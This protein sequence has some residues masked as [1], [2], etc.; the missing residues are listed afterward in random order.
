MSSG[1]SCVPRLECAEDVGQW[2]ASHTSGMQ[3]RVWRVSAC[4]WAANVRP[5]RA[6]T[7]VARMSVGDAMPRDRACLAMLVVVLLVAGCTPGR[8]APQAA[9]STAAETSTSDRL[10]PRTALPASATTVVAGSRAADLAIGTSRALFVSSPVVVLAGEDDEASITKAATTAADL[11]VPMLLTPAPAAPGAVDTAAAASGA[12]ADLRA[13]LSR[14]AVQS[15][16]TIGDRA[17]AWE[18]AG[19]SPSPTINM[20]PAST[21]VVPPGSVGRAALPDVVAAA[22]L[23]ELLVLALTGASSTAAVA[24]ARAAGA[25]V[26]LLPNPDPRT[27]HE[28]IQALASQPTTQVLALGGAF[29][30]PDQ[31]RGRIDIAATGVELPGGGQVVFPGRRMVALYGHPGNSRLGSLGE[32]PVDA[33]IARV[34]TVAAGYASLTG[35][36][37]VPAFEIIATVASA[38][39]GSGGD[40]SNESPVSLLRPWLDAART[41]GVYVVLDLQPG[42]SDFLTQAKLYTDLLLL[43]HVGLAL[44]PE[45]RLKPDQ[46]PIEQIGSVD[47]AEINATAQWLAD[48]TRTHNL[49]QKVLMVHQFRLDMITNRK[50]IKTDYDQLQIAI[51][52]DGFGSAGEKHNT[53][54]TLHVDP[55]ANVLWGWKNFYDEDKPTFTPSQTYAVTPAPVFVSYQ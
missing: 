1:R 52:A 34:K 24:T 44:D 29:G 12:G 43:P 26:V 47:A 32:Q 50:G 21:M 55:P 19:P 10:R 23:G 15:M 5:D 8:A 6:T 37:V 28:A 48:L 14:L 39:A 30:A 42:R 13:E 38:S 54:R 20:T 40:Y 36:Q 2:R 33:A 4:R 25:R 3:E 18:R 46:L 35:D 45:W 41:A 31:L 9:T 16:V 51:H 27:S 11:G 22:P 53:W 17:A 49:P 7:H